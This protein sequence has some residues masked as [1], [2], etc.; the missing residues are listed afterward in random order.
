MNVLEGKRI[1]L[2]VT[3]SIACYKALEL[4][5]QLTV[6][7]A[8]VDVIMTEEATRFV[9]PLA[10]QSLTH[11][12]VYSDMWA[13]LESAAAHIQLGRQ[14]Q[15]LLIAPATAHTIAALAAGLADTLILTTAL[16]TTAPILIA[17]AMETHMWQHPATQRNVAQLRAWGMYVLEPEE[18]LLASGQ[19]GRGRLPGIDR[20][21][22]ELRALLGRVYG[23]MRGRRVVVTAGGTHEPIDP[24]RFIGNRASG[25][26]GYALAAAAR[27]EG[28]QVTLIAG[29]VA[30]EA[31]VGVEVLRVETA[32]QMHAALQRV[33]AEAD[34]LLMNA[35]VADYRPAERLEHKRKKSAQGWTLELEPTTDIL[36][37]L[38]AERRPLKVGFAAET[39][40]LLS[41]ARDKLERKGLDL[42]V[43]NDALSS[44]GQPEIEL[45]LIEAGGVARVLP[46]QPKSAAAQQLIDYLLERWPARLGS[47]PARPSQ[48]GPSQEEAYPDE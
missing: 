32:Q 6:A 7:G 3:G 16:A 48:D 22:G 35:A 11:R 14:A 41:A 26:M 15:A 28:A 18:G 46:R 2:G 47:A 40:D 38:A 19:S 39:Q 12:P 8:L 21:E 36:Q 29:P 43:A 24:V 45:T 25:Q 27:D 44:I 10:F 30:L 34:L 4:A 20:L 23:R 5:R 1:V 33:I 37:S 17:P 42:I 9:T 13:T 31:P